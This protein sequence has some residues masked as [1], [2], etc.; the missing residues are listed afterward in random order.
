MMRLGEYRALALL[1]LCF[2]VRGVYYSS[3][4]PLWEGYD[5]YSHFAFVEYL[6]QQ[7]SLP[8]PGATR[9]SYEVE[10]SLQA[11]PL[12]WTQQDLQPGAITYER[13]WSL[14]PADRARRL[15]G[16]LPSRARGS[17]GRRDLRDHSSRLCITGP[18]PRCSPW[19]SASV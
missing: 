2:V 16:V 15:A 12:P 11:Y 8:V 5:E 3:A 14:T 17:G 18:W 6:V 13:W 7:G 1:W 4:M 19:R 10:S 9:N